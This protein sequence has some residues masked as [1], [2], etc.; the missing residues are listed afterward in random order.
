[1]KR[2]TFDGIVTLVGFGLSIFLFIAAG[3]LNWGFNFANSAVANQLSSQSI[4][5]PAD[6]GN[7]NANVTTVAFFKEN[8]NKLMSTGKQAQMYAD[9]YIGFHLS[10]MPT[11]A[12]ASAASRAASGA[13]LLYTSPSPRDGLLSRMP[14]SA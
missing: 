5:L 10:A 12:K 6:T 9:H 13:C 8:G 1:M 11:Y 4:M 14:S 3:L 7:K 2:R